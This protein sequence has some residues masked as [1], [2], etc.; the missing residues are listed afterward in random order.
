MPDL[1]VK[2][3]AQ[4]PHPCVRIQGLFVKPKQHQG[5]PAGPKQPRE[6]PALLNEQ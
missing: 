2:E 6:K 3:E 5:F 4:L 1:G